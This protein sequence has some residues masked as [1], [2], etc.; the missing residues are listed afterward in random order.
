[1]LPVPVWLL[2]LGAMLVGRRAEAARLCD[3]LQLDIGKTADLLAWTPPI[4]V[5]EGLSRAVC[6]GDTA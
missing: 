3:N 6:A 2:R 4:S 1:L 5:A